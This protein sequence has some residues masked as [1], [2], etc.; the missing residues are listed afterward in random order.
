MSRRKGSASSVVDRTEKR[1]R[2]R[3]QFGREATVEAIRAVGQWD[4]LA[5]NRY[6]Q[7]IDAALRMIERRETAR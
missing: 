7:G 2:R 1:V 5:A 4:T 3:I 6:L